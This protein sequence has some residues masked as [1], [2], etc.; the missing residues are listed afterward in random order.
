[1][2]RT[3]DAA[4]EFVDLMLRDMSDRR[5]TVALYQSRIISHV[6]WSGDSPAGVAPF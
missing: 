4:A 6:D 5:R 2:V 3:P 1:M